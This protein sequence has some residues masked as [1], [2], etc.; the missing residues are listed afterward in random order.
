MAADAM[1]AEGPRDATYLVEGEPVRLQN[2][3]AVRP[4]APGSASEI[5][6]QVFGAPTHG[7]IDGDGDTDAVFFLVQETGG[8]GTFYYVAA[9]HKVNGGYRG[10]TAVLIGDR[11]APHRLDIIH[12]VVVVDYLERAPGEP[13]ATQPALA[14]TGYLMLEGDTL[15]L[16]GSLDLGE[17]IV[18]GWVRIGHEVRSFEP[19][20]DPQPHWLSGD[21]PALDAVLESYREAFPMEKPY[22]P[23]LMVLAGS[24]SEPPAIGFGA[25]YAAGWRAT[26][27]VHVVHIGDC[28]SN[29]IVLDLPAR[30]EAVAS[31][32]KV[33]GRARG[34]WFFEGDFPLVLL[35]GRGNLVAQG[36]ATAKGE[37]MT[38]EFVPF[39]AMLR[40]QSPEH[41][42]GRLILKKDNPSDRCELDDAL[43]VPVIFK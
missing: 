8:S 43:I 15:T 26:R 17:R 23:L 37:W 36:L 12:G 22:T 5:R 27:V 35:D 2:G 34:T 18:E 39:S 30:G 11:I 16:A 10:G 19:C 29:Q 40:F 7:D 33:R 41:G 31:P 3:R 42:P 14:R 32:L 9:A 28:R 4:A 1:P 6:T 13:M 25:D 24:A 20:A 21:S 38:T